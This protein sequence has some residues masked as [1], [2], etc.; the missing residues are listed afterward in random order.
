MLKLPT[1]LQRLINELSK[2]P[3]IGPKTA[4]RLAFY[5]LKKDLVDIENLSSAIADVRRDIIFCSIC[6]NMAESDPCSVCADSKRDHSVICVVEEPLDALALDKSGEYHGVFHI[7]GGVLNP[8]EGVGPEQLQIDSLINRIRVGA[9]GA[10]SI[11]P[12]IGEGQTVKEIIIATNPSLEGETTAMHIAKII[13]EV[14]KQIS[15]SADKPIKITRIARGLPTGGD[16]EY[17]DDIT[18]MRAMEGRREY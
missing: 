13:R 16:L 8:L 10:D 5:L 12:Y 1:S 14:N 15:G 7:L 3:G 9:V 18:L 2:L 6:H 11:R 17:A 4:Q